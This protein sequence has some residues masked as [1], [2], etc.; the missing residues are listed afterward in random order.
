LRLSKELRCVVCQNET[1]DESEAPL[2]H[3]LRMI[4][5]ERLRAGDTDEQ[6]KEYLVRRYGHFVL[7]KPPLEPQT[8]LLWFAPILVLATGAGAAVLYVR[9]R[10]RA[11]AA[12]PPQL[13]PEEQAELDQMLAAAKPAE[14]E[15]PAGPS[16]AA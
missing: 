16:E 5:R 11:A 15:A 1:I 6:A 2:A 9:E 8:I 14:P 13:T 3:D 7:L 10:R 4:L 12:L